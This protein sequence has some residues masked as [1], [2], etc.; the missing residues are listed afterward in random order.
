MPQKQVSCKVWL[1]QTAKCGRWVDEAHQPVA[2][3]R[4]SPHQ[5]APSR[6]EIRTNSLYTFCKSTPLN[7]TQTKN[8]HQSATRWYEIPVEYV[9]LLNC[10]IVELNILKSLR[11]GGVST[12]LVGGKSIFNCHPAKN[13]EFGY[14]E[15]F[16]ILE[17]SEKI[18]L[19]GNKILQII[20]IF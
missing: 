9:E 6:P 10:W 2:K 17:T 3:I 13:N 4:T 5:S 11:V 14:L 8:L 19:F 12:C 16:A 1:V 15:N 18:L 7:F 20:S